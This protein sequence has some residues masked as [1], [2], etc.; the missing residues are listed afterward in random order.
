MPNGPRRD[1]KLKILLMTAVV[2]AI[3]VVL[4]L[5]ALQA[6][7]RG[8]MTYTNHWN[9]TVVAPGAILIGIFCL[10]LLAIVTWQAISRR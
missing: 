5:E 7:R 6:I 1:S 9:L 3:V 4:I 8:D 2:A 10:V